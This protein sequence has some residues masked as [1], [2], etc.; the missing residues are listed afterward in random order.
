M[1]KNRVV[2]RRLSSRMPGIGPNSQDRER[3]VSKLKADLRRFQN[4]PVNRR[5]AE[6]ADEGEQT[7]LALLRD[8]GAEA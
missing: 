3:L 7:C 5:E 8:L 6:S 2:D 1:A 4:V